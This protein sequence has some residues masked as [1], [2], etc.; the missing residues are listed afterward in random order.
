M[1]K[2]DC[3]IGFSIVFG[4]LIVFLVGMLA[5]MVFQNSDDFEKVEQF[6]KQMCA[7]HGLSYNDASLHDGIK[8][9]CGDPKKSIEDGY[10]IYGDK[11]SKW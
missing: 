7:E 10:L 2:D 4:V 9:Y 8:I 5:G 3:S 1:A 6:G 11:P